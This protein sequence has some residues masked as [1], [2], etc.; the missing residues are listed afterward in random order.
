MSDEFRVVE[1]SITIEPRSPR[2]LTAVRSRLLVFDKADKSDPGNE[3]IL[4]AFKA[5]NG[6][7]QLFAEVKYEHTARPKEVLAAILALHTAAAQ[8]IDE[9]NRELIEG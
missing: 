3:F 2:T 6:R 5:D 4:L 8:V 7:R 1:R 9:L